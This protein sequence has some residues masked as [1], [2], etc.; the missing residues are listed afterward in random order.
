MSMTINLRGGA[1]WGFKLAGGVDFKQPLSISKITSGGKADQHGVVEGS[2]ILGINGNDTSQMTHHIAMNMIKK[3]GSSVVLEIGKPKIRSDSFPPPPPSFSPQP[4]PT[5]SI[6]SSNSSS[7]ANDLYR[8][9]PKPYSP[10]GR[11]SPDGSSVLQSPSFQK[12]GEGRSARF[13]P[14]FT[15]EP[16]KKIEVSADIARLIKEEEEEK[17]RAKL[18]SQADPSSYK[19]PSNKSVQQVVTGNVNKQ[20]NTREPD[21]TKPLIDICKPLG[22]P[23]V[24]EVRLTECFPVPS[25][26]WYHNN[27]PTHESAEKDI[28]I[29]H[30]GLIHTLVLGELCQDQIG[31]Y[32][33]TI[34]NKNGSKSSRCQV[35]VDNEGAKLS[36]RPAYMNAPPPFKN[37]TSTAQQQQPKRILASSN[38][39]LY[40]NRNV[41]KVY[42]NQVVR[43]NQR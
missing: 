5:S 12:M 14:S 43:S 36:P 15:S 20:P 19:S 13:P 37:G 18:R 33:C 16:P 32:T 10:G 4:S 17:Q 35:T 7:R 8:P 6:S 23:V 27:K 41:E 40:S 26:H 1:P 3:S 28:K 22:E 9:T 25:V 39:D 2:F 42:T 34:M 29:L 30:N 24:L 21:F 11:R 31:R 38:V